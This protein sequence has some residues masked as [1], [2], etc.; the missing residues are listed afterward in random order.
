MIDLSECNVKIIRLRDSFWQRLHQS[1]TWLFSTLDEENLFIICNGI[2]Q[3][4]TINGAGTLQLKPGCL[5]YMNNAR[6]IVSR[7]I[8]NH[9]SDI[10]FQ[11]IEID[12][13][14]FL[15]RVN[16]GTKIQWVDVLIHLSSR[17]LSFDLTF[18]KKSSVSPIYRTTS[19]FQSSHF[20]HRHIVNSFAFME[21][22]KYCST[23]HR[24]H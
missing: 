11:E 10:V 14:L 17:W 19:L 9:N 5:A 13:N 1:N 21:L 20:V 7:N 18:T 22:H 2:E 16:N 3:I 24:E 6:F 8:K 12:I 15:N 23:S 4:R